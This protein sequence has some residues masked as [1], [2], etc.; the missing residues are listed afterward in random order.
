MAKTIKSVCWLAVILGAALDLVTPAQAAI[1]SE[2]AAAQTT[3]RFDIPAGPL[4]DA[5]AAFERL[6]GLTVAAPAQTT[7][8]GLSSPGATGTLTAEQALSR[9]LTDTGLT[10]RL[11]A[12]NAYTL[13]VRRVT[14]SV[15]VR[16]SLPYRAATT[17]A[18]TR[19]LTPLNDVPQAVTVITRAMIE[20]QRMQSMADVMRYVA[21][22]GMAQ[23][24]GNRDTPVLRG[25]S[26]TADFFVDGVRDDVQY[27][28]DLYNVDTVEA[29]KGPN[30]MMFGRG[31]AGGVIN[32]TTRQADWNTIR[33]VTLQTGSFDNRRATFD[34]GQPIGARWSARLTGMYEDSDSYRRGVSLGRYGLNPTLGFML[35]DATTLRVGYERFSDDRTADRGIPS[36]GN[37]PVNVDPEVF[38]GDPALSSSSATVDALTAGVDHAFP[39]GVL[40]RNRTRIAAYDKFYQNVYPSGSVSADGLSVP[41]AAYNNGTERTNLFS[42]TDVNFVAAAGGVTHTLLVGGEVG[43]QKTDNIR[44]TGYFTGVGPT[45]TTYAARVGAP[46]ISVPI[47]FRQSAT[48]ADNSGVATVAALYTQDQIEWSSRLQTIVGVRYDR[49]EVDFQNNRTAQNFNSLDHLVSPRAG[50]VYKPMPA[51]SLYTSYSLT[52]VPRAGE[53]LASLSLTNQALE[54]ERFTNYEAGAKWDARPELSVTAAVYKLDRTNVAVPDSV[55]PTRFLLVAGQRTRGFELGISG[56]ITPAWTTVGAYAY[57][58]GKITQTLSPTSRAGATLAQLPAHT[59]SLWNKYRMSPRW[60]VGAGIIH[61]G[62]TFASTDNLVALPAFTRVDGA[63]FLTL[64]RRMGAQVNVENLFDERYYPFAHSNSNI[65][66]GSPRAVRLSLTTHF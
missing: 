25:T 34:L 21:G 66:P 18:A 9:L 31:G 8:A 24:E 49:F 61:N 13:E 10:F 52:Y 1:R 17:V 22:A 30:A 27:F 32:R 19:T 29:M 56:N 46:T 6:T 63:L 48:D 47:A 40:L 59:F 43:R 11:S 20:D 39:H 12:V 62:A 55:D 50:V 3:F 14:E 65:T 23:G 54:P 38:F 44:H 35:T 51:V 41:L 53:Q 33:E 28:R 2:T 26:T 64:T 45:A 4:D 5:L 37:A 42:Q 15:Q 58:D 60:A 57:Q 16:A 36:L 7:I